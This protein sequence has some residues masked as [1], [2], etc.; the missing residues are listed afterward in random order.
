MGNHVRAER[1][2][3]GYA[4][5]MKVK[6]DAATFKQAQSMF[7]TASHAGGSVSLFG[8]AIGGSASASAHSTGSTSF[9]D[10]KIDAESFTIS[11]PPISSTY[12]CLVGVLAKKI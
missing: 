9:K 12:P 1:I 8:F 7:S 11:I 10:V 6:F 5:G 2:L 3:V 4:P